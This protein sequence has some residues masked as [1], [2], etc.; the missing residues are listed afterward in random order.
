MLQPTLFTTLIQSVTC[1]AMS[2]TM[3]SSFSLSLFLFAFDSPAKETTTKC[4]DKPLVS[5]HCFSF[6]VLLRFYGSN[7]ISSIDW[8][9]FIQIAVVCLSFFLKILDW[10]SRERE[11]KSI[12]EIRQPWNNKRNQGTHESAW[13]DHPVQFLIA[14][15]VTRSSARWNCFHLISLKCLAAC[16]D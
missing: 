7:H 2:K 14:R 3:Q 12:D 11:R 10:R 8:A 5:F 1:F 15:N 9:Y 13:N 16:Q 4:L 6:L